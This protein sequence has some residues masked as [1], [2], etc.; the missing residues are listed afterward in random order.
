MFPERI[1]T[2]RLRLERLDESVDTLTF[3]RICSSDD[4]I[5]E[6]TAYMPWS[7]HETPK[8]TDEFLESARSRWEDRTG[9][10]Y[11]IYPRDGED[12]AGDLA[13]VG[14]LDVDWDRRLGS[15]GTWLRKP[16]WGRGYSGERAAAL[17]EL[18]FERLELEVVE[19]THHVDNEKSCRAIEKYVDRHGGRKEGVLRNWISHDDHV[20]D[21]VRYTISREEWARAEQ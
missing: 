5:D 7:P 17:L 14:G 4:G 8:E 20:A 1:E 10:D 18:A 11:A 9:A 6:V 16:F 21:E 15:L 13:G 3:Y 2:D 12:G 19:V